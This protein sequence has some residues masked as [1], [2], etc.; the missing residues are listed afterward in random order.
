LSKDALAVFQ[1]A[2][3][4]AASRARSIASALRVDIG[5]IGVEADIKISV[6]TIEEKAPKAMGSDLA[7]T[8]WTLAV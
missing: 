2:T 1:L 7:A 5:G 3:N 6:K 8:S 4:A